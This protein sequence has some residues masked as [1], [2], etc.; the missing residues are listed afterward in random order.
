MLEQVQPICLLPGKQCIQCSKFRVQKEE[1]DA[2]VFHLAQLF[3]QQLTPRTNYLDHEDSIIVCIDDFLRRNICQ[4]FAKAFLPLLPTVQ[5]SINVL[6][7]N[8]YTDTK[9]H[10]KNSRQLTGATWKIKGTHPN[11][12]AHNIV[13]DVTLIVLPL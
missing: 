8:I 7:C 4:N 13:Y 10:A 3:Y 1:C 5:I 12:I 2:K 9:Y 6:H 11:T